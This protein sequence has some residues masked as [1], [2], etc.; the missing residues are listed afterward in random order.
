MDHPYNLQMKIDAI[1]SDYDGTLCPTSSISQDNSNGSIIPKRLETI[2]W[3]ISEKIDVC[4]VSSKDFGF[5]H[6]RT[7]FAKI[8]SCIMGIETLV[9][10]RHKLKAVMRE[11]Q[12]QY[13]SSNNNINNKTNTSFGECKDKLQCILSSHIPSNKDILQDNSRLLDSLAD[14]ISINFK[15]ITVERK[16]TSD[17]QILAGI[18]IDYRHLKDWQSYKRNIEPHLEE[19]FQ[20]NINSSSAN[21]HYYIQ[22]YSTHPFMDIYSVRCNKGLAFDA[23][24][25]ALSSFNADDGIRQNILYLGDSENDNPAFKRADV[26]IGVCSDKRLNPELTCQY[27]VEF[28]QLSIFLKRL[29]YNDFV[30]SDKLLLNL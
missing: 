7:K 10:K 26:S 4:I 8:L 29:Q 20:R 15:N 28:D 12:Y 13:D 3:N 30:F 23:T 11:N 5:L 6:R 9:L 27:L 21:Q 14:E 19:I 16:F 1:L 17:N 22:T 24:I 25:S 2:I 18:T